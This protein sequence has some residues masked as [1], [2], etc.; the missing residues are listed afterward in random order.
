[1]SNYNNCLNGETEEGCK[2]FAGCKQF[3]LP[4]TQHPDLVKEKLLFKL[5]YY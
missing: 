4:L 1:M 2:F 5:R 3:V